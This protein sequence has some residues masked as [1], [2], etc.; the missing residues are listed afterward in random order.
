MALLIVNIHSEF[1]V[2]MF[3]NGR[4]DKLSKFLHDN[5]DNL[6]QHGHNTS[7]NSQ[8]KNGTTV[9]KILLW[10]PADSEQFI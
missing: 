7:E 4:N 1:Q 9:S 3:S 8:P 2:Y 5:D 6:R 10:L